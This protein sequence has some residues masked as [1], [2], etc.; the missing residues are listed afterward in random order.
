M[1]TLIELDEFK[2]HAGI[3]V[4]TED[5]KLTLM[6]NAAEAF[7]ASLIGRSLTGTT[8]TETLDGDGEDY[9]IL[10]NFP[11]TSLTSVVL[12]GLAVQV[13]GTIDTGKAVRATRAGKLERVDGGAF[14]AGKENVIAVYVI[15]A[16][17]DDLKLSIMDLVMMKRNTL[18]GTGKKSE[19]L[20]SYSY[21][22]GDVTKVPLLDAM[23]S[24]YRDP[25]AMVK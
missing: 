10:E 24:K 2:K 6:I 3:T 20:G 13:S 23:I 19:Q 18:A 21:E 5:R 7:V 17:G 1:P 4:D 22:I 12:D 16:V 11:V 15:D 8:I 25:T 14:T 9:L